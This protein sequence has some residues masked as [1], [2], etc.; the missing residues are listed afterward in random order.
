[1][2]KTLKANPY[3]AHIPSSG[4]SRN[5]MPLYTELRDLYASSDIHFAQYGGRPDAR[6]PQEYQ[7]MVINAV[8]FDFSD[9]A[10]EVLTLVQTF[11]VEAPTEHLMRYFDWLGALPV[12][13]PPYP[14]MITEMDTDVLTRLGRTIAVIHTE[15]N[16]D[17]TAGF[18][19]RCL[20]FFAL[21]RSNTKAQDA[22]IIG[23]VASAFVQFDQFGQLIMNP[24]EDGVPVPSLH[25]ETADM[26]AFKE[27]FAD[28]AFDFS[29]N[30][31]TPTEY[32]L[33]ELEDSLYIGA[34]TMMT[35]TLFGC[36]LLH[37]KNVE[38][39]T[40]CLPR[41]TARYRARRNL[42]F[43]EWK[44]LK[45]RPVRRPKTPSETADVMPGNKHVKRLHGVEGHFSEY[46]D[47]PDGTPYL[48]PDGTPKG[49]LFGKISGVFWIPAHYRGLADLG[50][51]LKT[52]DVRKPL[53]EGQ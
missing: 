19:T 49:K 10:E 51:I 34:L 52:Y 32:M 9:V 14:L 13:L 2:T 43:I 29:P 22:G 36:S 24:K 7:E 27:L 11:T 28:P 35:Y 33:S 30:H 16:D 50:T 41:Q 17:P 53:E 4:D 26:N 48:H 18:L 38:E 20:I 8:P 39:A 3:T 6:A 31:R 23:P 44:T 47:R 5:R 25:I 42:P 46:G 45:V 1:M 21:S 15:R 12:S 40:V 37:C